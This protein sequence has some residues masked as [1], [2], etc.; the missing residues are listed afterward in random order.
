MQLELNFYTKEELNFYTKEDL[1]FRGEHVRNVEYFVYRGKKYYIHN[2][3]IALFFISKLKDLDEFK[4]NLIH[5]FGNKEAIRRRLVSR[6]AS[7]EDVNYFIANFVD[8]EGGKTSFLNLADGYTIEDVLEN[9][10]SNN[11]RIFE[12]EGVKLWGGT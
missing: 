7:Q 1:D 3:G 4:I 10:Y 9:Y 11:F 12:I 5:H 2:V 8:T 6:M